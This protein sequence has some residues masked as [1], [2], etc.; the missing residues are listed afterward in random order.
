MCTVFLS[1][2]IARKIDTSCHECQL[3]LMSPS[4]PENME[5]NDV[6]MKAAAELIVSKD[7]GG[8]VYPTKFMIELA[9]V[10]ER[11][12]R[13]LMNADNLGQKGTN[14]LRCVVKNILGK[15]PADFA[16]HAL[17]TQHGIDNH[18]TN[19]LNI[20]VDLFFT[21]RINHRAKKINLALHKSMI[22][23]KSTK[24]VIFTGQ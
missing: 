3:L 23:N 22:R 13:S 15:P 12:F 24:L 19:L 14:Y 7:R 5:D 1:R 2:Y 20:A 16:E 21:V 9:M 4:K 18:Y 6:M 8:L 10:L 17:I 11:S